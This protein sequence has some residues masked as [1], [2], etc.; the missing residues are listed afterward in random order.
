MI[1]IIIINTTLFYT[2]TSNRH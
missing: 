2:I 1:I